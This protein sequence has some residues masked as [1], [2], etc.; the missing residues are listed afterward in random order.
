MDPGLS[1][2]PFSRPSEQTI[3]SLPYLLH[4]L[5][6]TYTW[7][8]P[9]ALSI[10]IFSLPFIS[11]LCFL[12]RFFF[13]LARSP[14]PRPGSKKAFP[15]IDLPASASASVYG[16]LRRDYAPI[17]ALR[18]APIRVIARFR[19]CQVQIRPGAPIN[20]G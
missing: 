2:T 18:S 4:A 15:T 12:R 7:L 9:R 20:F 17:R 6:S 11:T 13:K 8:Y 19:I 10:A 1:E 16:E 14:R 5:L 3:R